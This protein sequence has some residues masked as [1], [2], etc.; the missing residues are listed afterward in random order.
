MDYVKVIR[1][2]RH[3]MTPQLFLVIACALALA[4]SSS[5]K[6]SAGKA[7]QIPASEQSRLLSLGYDGFDT[8]TGE[9][10]WRSLNA[11]AC[12]DEALKLID[13]Y[14]SVHFGDMTAA[15]RSEASF[16]AGQALAFADRNTEAITHFATALTFATGD[17]W[18]TYVQAHVAYATGDLAALRRARDQYAEIAP[19]SMRL[20]FLSGL[21]AC[22]RQPY[23]EAAHCAP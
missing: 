22:P 5:A 15:Q 2:I 3:P 13:E 8:D 20:G 9:W 7:C 4:Q 18:T 23:M 11:R 12:T 10:S 17:E 16:H 19:N 6:A 1:A 21:L 14:V